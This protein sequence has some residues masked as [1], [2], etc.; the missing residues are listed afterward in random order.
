LIVDHVAEAGS[1]MRDTDKLHRIDPAIGSGRVV[2]D[3][4]H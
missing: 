2:W 3:C 1:G 4:L